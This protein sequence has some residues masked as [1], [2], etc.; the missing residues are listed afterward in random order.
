MLPPD[1]TRLEKLAV[2]FVVVIA[3]TLIVATI[4]LILATPPKLTHYLNLQ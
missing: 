1:A 3:A 2:A 4:L